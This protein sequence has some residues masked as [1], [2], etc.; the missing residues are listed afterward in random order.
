M[1]KLD[2]KSNKSHHDKAQS[3]SFCNFG[4]FCSQMISN[5]IKTPA[6]STP[7]LSGFVHFFTKY[8]ESFTNFLRGSITREL[9]SDMICATNNWI[10]AVP[11][12]QSQPNKMWWCVEMMCSIENYGEMDLKQ[13]DWKRRENQEWITKIKLS[14]GG[15]ADMECF[16][17]WCP[18]WLWPLQWQQVLELAGVTFVQ[19]IF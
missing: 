4:E 13:S 16:S 7:F 19:V 11:K 15:P 18:C 3:S 2:K 6:P 14:E 1:N 10:V 17:M 5:L 12:C 9:I 8:S